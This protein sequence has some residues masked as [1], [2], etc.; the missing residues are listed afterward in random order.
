MDHSWQLTSVYFELAD[1]VY[2]L[3][4]QISTLLLEALEMHLNEGQLHIAKQASD[5]LQLPSEFVVDQNE[6]WPSHI[7]TINFHHHQFIVL[8]ITVSLSIV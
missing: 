6:R 1:M 5:R 7:S 3:R 8:I 4:R 2:Y